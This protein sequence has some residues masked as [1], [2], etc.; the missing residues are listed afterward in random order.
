MAESDL[1]RGNVDTIILK[2]L[3]E[4]DR[5]GYDLIKQINARGDGQWEIK[6]PTVYACLKRLE[7]QGFISS[8]WD[9][10]E[11]DG[12]RRKYYSLTESGREVFL[13]YKSEY[14]RASA[15]FGGII[16]GSDVPPI[17]ADDDFSDV[18]E[19]GYTVPKRKPKRK[20]KQAPQTQEVQK[21][22]EPE[23]PQP[24]EETQNSNNVIPQDIFIIL[25]QQQKMQQQ[26]AEQQELE[27]REKQQAEEEQQRLEAERREQ[28]LLEQARRERA[29]RERELLELAQLE[30]ER[31]EQELL[32]LRLS[33]QEQ[34]QQELAEQLEQQR[35]EHERLEQQ[36]LEH[37][38]EEKLQQQERQE[39]EEQAQPT[40]KTEP[41]IREPL[42]PKQ[43]IESY[44]AAES[45]ESF[46]DAQRKNN[47]AEDPAPVRTP[48]QPQAAPPTVEKEQPAPAPA[49]VAPIPEPP[50]SVP[51]MRRPTEPA[52]VRPTPL[53]APVTGFTEEEE[54]PARREYKS[55][56][57]ELVDRFEVTPPDLHERGAVA[58]EQAATTE[59]ATE[60]QEN[61]QLS[62][63]EQSVRALGNSL[64]VR[65]HNNSA[66][67]YSGK[68]YYYSNRLMMTHYIIM[69]AVMFVLGLA[70]FL[71]FYMGLN[72]RM[73]Y[74]YMLYIGAGLLP[75]AMFIVSVIKYAADV[76]K[77]KRI[78]VNFRFSMI[79]RIVIM[80]Q[81]CV[82]VYCLNLIWGMP[83]GFSAG[84]IPSLVLPA[85]Y[86]L[87]IPISELIFMNLLKSGNY[88]VDVQ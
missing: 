35:L 42:D 36:L 83:V 53:P 68:H 65:S 43:I 57:E 38:L 12:G 17:P 64:T 39:S 5:Y 71:T 75:I 19:E 1:I 4:G 30:Q 61:R 67:E 29:E 22:E 11:S 76:N 58:A 23:Q 3:Y 32:E 62:K 8:Y 72:M 52:P 78:N 50:P 31:L 41:P 86:A 25:E 16:S 20:P 7:K 9:S 2:V 6:Q 37:Q 81:V 45:G 47:L 66:K 70:L 15:L 88:A 49:P 18:E 51:A 34:R 80:L 10:S 63:V 73:R 21:A 82:I 48:P 69:C 55:V 27:E 46:S 56:L 14:E 13:K 28:E 24:K 85:V 77:K 60:P 54:S 59:R 26:L 74:D 33:E 84:F 44:Y 87:F 40:E 79:I